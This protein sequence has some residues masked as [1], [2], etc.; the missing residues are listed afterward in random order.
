M[1][2]L[3]YRNRGGFETLVVT[4]SVGAPASTVFGTFRAG[5]RY[6]ELRRALPGGNFVVQEQATFAPADGISRWMGS[7]AADH[8]G[9][10]AVGYSV[11]SG[12]AGG[13]V[14]PGIRYAG[15]LAG[16]PPGGLTQG[17]ATLINGTGVQTSTGNR[18]GDYSALSVD[19]SDDCTF[20]YTNEYYTAAGQAASSAGWQTRIGRFKF[21]ECTPAEMGTL[22]GTITYCDSG[23][24]VVGA[25][26]HVSDGHTG[27]TLADGSYSIKV[28]PGDYSV[29]VSAEG[30][31]CLTTPS[32][33]VTVNNGGTT[34]YSTCLSGS[35][36][37]KVDS[38]TISGGN[39]D[40]VINGNE[41]NMMDVVVSNIGCEG[42]TNVSAVL[43]TT[44][45]GVTVEQSN[46]TYPD[47]GQGGSGSNAVPFQFSTSAAFACGIAI[48]FTLT[49]TTDQ[50]MFVTNFSKP[51]C[52]TPT[53]NI[54]G[55]IAAGDTTMTGRIVRN[56]V[57]SSCSIAKVYPGTQDLLA[58]RR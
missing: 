16:D 17:E 45:P 18:W 32:A 28:A 31:S 44:T 38:S 58:N 12:A 10:L 9:N 29:Q 46:S 24:P 54:S 4:H 19:P 25:L 26:V 22:S 35:P 27:V 21:A 48:D 11:S 34:D 49:V 5:V 47:M 23:A 42:A 55:S 39:G 33:N 50:G 52:Q 30:A 41:C 13:N 7:A 3:Q 40:T 56:G 57:A 8:Q 43:S 14:F 1:H 37:F 15:R 53:M 51:T 36:N 20:W 6:Y 2:R